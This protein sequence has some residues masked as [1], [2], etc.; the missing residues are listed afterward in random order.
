MRSRLPTIA[1]LAGMVHSLG[2]CCAVGARLC[3]GLLDGLI[4]GDSGDCRSTGD[5]R[6]DFEYAH[7]RAHEETVREEFGD[8]TP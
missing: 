5:S 8:V 3:E 7:L 4:E 6:Q 1:L 2:G